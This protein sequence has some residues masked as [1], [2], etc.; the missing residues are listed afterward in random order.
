MTTLRGPACLVSIVIYPANA[1]QLQRAAL[2]LKDQVPCA[3]TNLAR[4]LLATLIIGGT[5]TALTVPGHQPNTSTWLAL[6]LLAILA[7]PASYTALSLLAQS[8]CRKI[9]VRTVRVEAQPEDNTSP[10]KQSLR[11]ALETMRTLEVAAHGKES[12]EE[13]LNS[14]AQQHSEPPTRSRRTNRAL[15]PTLYAEILRLCPT[16]TKDRE[17]TPC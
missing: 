2:R 8:I 6:S 14:W 17:S 10:N 9:E 11:T 16:Q 15:D 1:S 5:A 13:T 12:A 3:T 7:I 4:T